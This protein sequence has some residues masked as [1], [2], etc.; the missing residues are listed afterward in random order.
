MKNY[1]I[2]IIGGGPAGSTL[3]RLLDKKLS[4][5]LINYNEKVKPCGGLL[6][7]DAQGIG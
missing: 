1:D 2:I 6:A 4:V 3:A 5:L 7:P